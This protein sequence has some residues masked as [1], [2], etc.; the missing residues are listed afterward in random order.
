MSLMVKAN[1]LI[2]KQIVS[3]KGEM[4]GEVDGV[5]V[6]LNNWQVTGLY[7]SLTDDATT[8]LGF[9]KSFW[10]RIV[11]NLPTTLIVSVGEVIPLSNSIKSLKDLVEQVKT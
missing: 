3:A 4:L 6:D 10:S 7:V 9:K 2:G 11:I 1:K 5:D 8:E